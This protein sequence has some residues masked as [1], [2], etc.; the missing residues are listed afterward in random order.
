VFSHGGEKDA[1][2]VLGKLATY[3]FGKLKAGK[4]MERS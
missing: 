3:H 4:V 2:N 1:K